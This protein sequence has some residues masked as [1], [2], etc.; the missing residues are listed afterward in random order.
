MPY[1]ML[2]EA[3]TRVV[4]NRTVFDF[5]NSMTLVARTLQPEQQEAVEKLAY[6]L[7]TERFKLT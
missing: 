2:D 7:L 4:A 1:D 6:K 5:Y 3:L